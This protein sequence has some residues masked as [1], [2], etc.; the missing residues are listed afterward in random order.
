MT[1]GYFYKKINKYKLKDEIICKL[2]RTIM[3]NYRY[4]K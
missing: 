4:D 2:P 3:C 1:M